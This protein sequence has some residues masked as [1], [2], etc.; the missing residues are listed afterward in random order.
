MIRGG[1]DLG[2]GVAY[3]IAKSG[4][5]IIISELAQPLCVRRLVC[6]SNAVFQGS[7]CIEGIEARLCHSAA[8]AVETCLSGRIAVLIDPEADIRRKVHPPVLIDARMTKR[9]PDIDRSAADLVIGLGPGFIAGKNCH[10]AI[11]TN[12][13]SHLGRVCWKGS[14]EADTGLP[15]SVASH[16][17]DRVLRAPVDGIM[18][19]KRMIGDKVVA[20]EIIAEID[21]NPISAGFDGVIRGLLM[22]GMQ[23]RR[24][25]KIG[26]IDPRNDPALCRL[27]SDKAL[28]IGGGVFE[29]MMTREEIRKTLFGSIPC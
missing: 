9:E 14:V 20:G 1:G 21:R 11:E 27:I 5:P 15:E 2:S 4:L 3:R 7:I 17:S 16:Q 18:L 10:A 28:A 22:S 26:D 19:E 13:G 29:A 25:M 24:G 12:R 6:Y 8:E 23:V